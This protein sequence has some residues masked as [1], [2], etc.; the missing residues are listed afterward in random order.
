MGSANLTDKVWLWADVPGLA[1]DA[2]KIGAIRTVISGGL[3]KGVMPAWKGRL[4]AEQIK[5]LT[6]YV[7]ELG[8]GK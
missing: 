3:N 2:A 5:L 7:H 1:D 4:N 8:G 6:V